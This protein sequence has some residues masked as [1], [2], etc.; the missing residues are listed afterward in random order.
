M[1]DNI[2]RHEYFFT[3]AHGA[4]QCYLQMHDFPKKFEVCYGSLRMKQRRFNQKRF[5]NAQEKDTNE[6]DFSKM[7]AAEKKR[8]KQKARKAAQKA[9]KLEE[10]RMLEKKKAQEEAAKEGKKRMR[11]LP[12]D[13]DPEGT[14]AFAEALKDPLE[15]AHSL[16]QYLLEDNVRALLD[17]FDIQVRRKKYIQAMSALARASRVAKE[18]AEHPDI[19]WRLA[20][21]VA[22]LKEGRMTFAP[23]VSHSSCREDYGKGVDVAIKAD[24]TVL[25]VVKAL[26]E[27][28]VGDADTRQSASQYLD[29]VKGSSKTLRKVSAVKALLLLNPKDT[30]SLLK[31]L[32][33]MTADDQVVASAVKVHELILLF[34]CGTNSDIAD[35]HKN[36]CK[37][38]FPRSTYFASK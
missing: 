1:E 14:I 7:T 20:P 30:S 11:K 38:R 9:K 32:V 15:K 12:V 23:W 24:P 33:A 19:H 6:V 35:Q 27:E 17:V 22:F 8:A 16:L 25:R 4:I 26:W 34:S 2:R 31:Q 29:K 3:G 21:F 10:Q 37:A 18:G 13:K 5:A 36:E 28:V